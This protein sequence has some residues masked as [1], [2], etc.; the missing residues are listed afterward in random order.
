[1]NNILANQNKPENLQKLAAQ[2]QLYKTAKRLLIWQIILT[3]PVTIALSFCKL[4]QDSLFGF[5]VTAFVALY[6]ILLAIADIFIFNHFISQYRT[7]AAKIQEL[8]DCSAY[9][10]SW[11]NIEIGKEPN[12]E[13]INEFSNQYV[14]IP[15]SPLTDWYPFEIG[16]MDKQ[17]AILTCQKTNLYYDASLRRMYKNIALIVSIATFIILIATSIGKNISLPSFIVYVLA[18]FFPILIL[19]F[20][21]IFEHGKS[22]KSASELHDRV[23]VVNPYNAPSMEQLRSIQNK[24]YCHRKDSPLMPDFFYNKKRKKLEDSMHRNATI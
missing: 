9:E 20:K 24:I 14:E 2:R 7:D 15:D 18:P 23:N 1:M 21:I 17:Q 5:S 22:I 6:G 19:T 16:S 11:N 12:Q 10:M 13:L 8:F 3:V 4:L